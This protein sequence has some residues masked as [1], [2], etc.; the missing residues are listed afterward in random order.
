MAMPADAMGFAPPGLPVMGARTTQQVKLA[1][2]SALNA[3]AAG[4]KTTN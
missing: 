1:T 2:T 4:S 3:S